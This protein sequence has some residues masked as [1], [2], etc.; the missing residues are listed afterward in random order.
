MKGKRLAVALAA[1]AL[2]ALVAAACGGD[3][4]TG[5]TDALKNLRGDVRVDGSSTVFLIS[6]AVAEEFKKEAPNVKV[7]VV[8]TSGTGGGFKKFCSGESD[9]QDASRAIKN[10]EKALCAGKVEYV[11]L[12]IALDGLSV[13]THK[14]NNWVDCF[15]TA[16]LKK[17]FEPGSKINN[18]SQIRSGFPNKPLKLFGPGTD[19]GTYDFFT[20]E[21][22]G[23]EGAGRSDPVYT[24]N[25]DD[26][27][28]VQGI[29]GEA[30]SLGYFGFGYYEQNQSILKLSGVTTGSDPST[31]CV[32]PTKETVIG[33][34][35]KPLSRPLFIYVA[36]TAVTKPQ[37]AAFVDFYLANVSTLAPEVGFVAEPDA[38]LA[39]AKQAWEAAK[40]AN[41]SPAP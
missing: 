11:E 20:K 1:I 33:G 5:G 15:T 37:I 9:I 3:N 35:Y 41:A 22:N 27:F 24:P 29:S 2:L 19:S 14:D 26:Q 6:E 21:I 17:I 16:E 40:S 39:A 4:G 18:W 7:S 23:E 30:N 28:L 25:E 32:K 12:K 34:T 13:V 8:G 36:K 38:D 10:D 31:G